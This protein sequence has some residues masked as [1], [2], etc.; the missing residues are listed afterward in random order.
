MLHH[1]HD[2]L[3]GSAL[4]GLRLELDLRLASSNSITATT[5][6]CDLLHI[7]ALLEGVQLLV[8]MEVRSV[9]RVA[10]LLVRGV[11]LQDLGGGASGGR[12]GANLRLRGDYLL[13]R[14]LAELWLLNR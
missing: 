11:A 9:V 3:V 5:L 1:M 4:V 7:E 13:L 6:G 12:G 10:D 14:L 8:Q 2:S